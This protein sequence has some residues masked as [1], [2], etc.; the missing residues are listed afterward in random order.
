MIIVIKYLAPCFKINYDYNGSVLTNKENIDSWRSCSEQCTS[1]INCT[2][3]VWNMNTKVCW[4]KTVT[5]GGYTHDG[6]VA[7]IRGCDVI[8]G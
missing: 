8:T 1:V 6:L 7:G 5:T 2:V 3:W 4:M